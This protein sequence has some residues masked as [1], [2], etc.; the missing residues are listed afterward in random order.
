MQEQKRDWSGCPIVQY[1]P[2]KM[3]GAPNVGGQRITPD[4]FVDNY[5]DGLS[6]SELQEQFPGVSEQNIRIVL[7]YA[8]QRGFLVARPS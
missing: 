1:D 8:A 7:H 5:N 2:K 6:V 4:A 3:S